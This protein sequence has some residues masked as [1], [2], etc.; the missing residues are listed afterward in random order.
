[1]SI[2]SGL[3]MPSLKGK[4]FTNNVPL[5]YNT[6]LRDLRKCLTKIGINPTGFGEHSGHRGGT[7][8]AASAGASMDELVL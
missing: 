6:A 5:C 1:M 7:T 8:A 2:K 4:S 3:L